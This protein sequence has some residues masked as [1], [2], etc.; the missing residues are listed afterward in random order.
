MTGTALKSLGIARDSVVLATKGFGAMGAGPND[1][2]ASRGHLT[3]ALKASLKR[4]QDNLDYHEVG[5]Y[6]EYFRY[7][8]AQALFQGDYAAWQR[9]AYR[10]S[11]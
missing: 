11:R 9:P 10:R 3:S 1:R 2:G 8:M 4:L 6:A 5:N 7:Y